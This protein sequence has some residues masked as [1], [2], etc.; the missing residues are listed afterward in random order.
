M[1]ILILVP[2]A[3]ST[4]P[5]ATVT[6]GLPQASATSGFS[7]PT[8]ASTSRTEKKADI[9]NRAK[10]S[11]KK[12]VL[13]SKHRES[14]AEPKK[15][16]K[17]GG[18]K[19][20]I[21]ALLHRRQGPAIEEVQAKEAVIIKGEELQTVEEAP[22]AEDAPLDASIVVNNAPVA[23]EDQVVEEVE[24]VKDIPVIEA[25][26]VVDEVP[27]VA[28]EAQVGDEDPQRPQDNN[29]GPS[30]H[31]GEGATRA[32]SI[33]SHDFIDIFGAWVRHAEAANREMIAIGLALPHGR[34]RRQ[35]LQDANR[36]GQQIISARTSIGVAI[37]ALEMTARGI[38]RSLVASVAGMNMAQRLLHPA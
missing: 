9:F 29:S 15:T 38:E 17:K 22:A 10:N 35:V 20:R 31:A 27:V 2:T 6:N 8:A 21:T 5:D 18:M 11:L 28:N 12:S 24:V 14:G 37:G 33:P 32:Q 23:K 34:N 4:S 36:I 25:A 19:D 7:R 1:L 13:A 16:P 26:P 3:S 30:G